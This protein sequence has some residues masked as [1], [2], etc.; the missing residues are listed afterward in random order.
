VPDAQHIRDA[1]QIEPL[2]PGRFRAVSV[3]HDSGRQVVEGGQMIGQMIVATAK[4]VP[5]KPIRS[6]SAVFGRAGRT[7]EPLDID[8]DTIHVGRTLATSTARIS[9]SGR[10]LSQAV[11]LSDANDPDLIRHSQ[12]FPAD[13]GRPDEAE[14]WTTNANGT[15]IRIANGVD[16]AEVGPNGP[17]Q[18]LVWFRALGGPERDPAL[19]QALASS[20]SHLF[21]IAAA[22]RPHEGVGA[23]MAHRSLSTGVLT[24]SITFHDTIDASEWL[25][26]AQESTYAGSGR[27]YGRGNVFAEDGRHVASFSQD[28][29]LRE[30]VTQ[31]TPSG[32]QS[33]VL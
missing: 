32:Q 31:F 9:Q 20:R 6:V 25:L 13:A 10:L 17:P 26:F 2:T 8:I 23:K 12:P 14:P 7:D 18:M 30:S 24:H 4:T 15:E 5:G 28:S 29:L 1:L 11:L 3:P 27:A 16:M 22:M 21:L 33:M 19:N